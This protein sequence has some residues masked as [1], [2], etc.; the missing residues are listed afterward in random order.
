MEQESE[1]A[2]VYQATVITLHEDAS[3]VTETA[4]DYDRTDADRRSRPGRRVRADVG[5]HRRRDRHRA[6][7]LPGRRQRRPDRAVGLTEVEQGGTIA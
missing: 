7:A 2:D 1:F 3:K 4:G 5:E 6:R